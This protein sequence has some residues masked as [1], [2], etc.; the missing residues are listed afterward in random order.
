MAS[1]LPVLPYQPGF[2]RLQE[3]EM[4]IRVCSPGSWGLG[5]S[6]CGPE[7]LRVPHPDGFPMGG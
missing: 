6:G 7:C 4:G 2:P 5:F 1:S 3:N